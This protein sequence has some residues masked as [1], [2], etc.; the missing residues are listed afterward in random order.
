MDGAGTT[1][2]FNNP[3]ALAVDPVTGIASIATI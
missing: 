3:L 1:A 2:K